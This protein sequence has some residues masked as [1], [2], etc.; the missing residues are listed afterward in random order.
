MELI[1]FASLFSLKNLSLVCADP[2]QIL[3]EGMGRRKRKQVIG[4]MGKGVSRSSMVDHRRK[5]DRSSTR[6]RSTGR[7]LE[8][9]KN[10]V[11]GL[12]AECGY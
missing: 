6:E 1:C 10:S 7:R 9:H 5:A 12:G 11:A 2:M 4:P 3:G 8:A